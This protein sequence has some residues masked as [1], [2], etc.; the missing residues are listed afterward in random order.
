MCIRD[1]LSAGYLAAER[2]VI[3]N[4]LAQNQN[5]QKDL[6]TQE[7]QNRHLEGWFFRDAQK[8]IDRL[9]DKPIKD[10]EDH[11]DLLRIHRRVYHHPNQSPRMKP[12]GQTIVEMGQQLDL[13]YL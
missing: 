4:N 9:E 7:L 6:L 12:G 5:L 1:R 8:E 10:W 2:F 3:F 13:V 11:L